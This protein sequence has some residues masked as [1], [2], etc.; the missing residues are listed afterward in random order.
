MRLISRIFWIVSLVAGLIVTQAALGERSIAQSQSIAPSQSA[1]IT[2][3]IQRD[4]VAEA[5]T[6]ADAAVADRFAAGQTV[7]QLYVLGA[8]Q[9][10]IAPILQIQVTREQWQQQPQT[11]VWAKYVGYTFKRSS[12][13]ATIAQQS[14][15][16]YKP[17]GE[18][19]PN[20]Y[21]ESSF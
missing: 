13:A 19:E 8:R 10:D 15:P 9:G 3:E 11:A 5:M 7:V 20:F 4:P 17:E 12:N 14:R 2:F 16:H 6:I 18:G 1:S 21:G